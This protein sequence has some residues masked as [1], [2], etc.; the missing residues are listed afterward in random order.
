MQLKKDFLLCGWLIYNVA[1]LAQSVERGTF[2]PEVEGSS[3]SSGENIFPQSVP[4][5][6][7]YRISMSNILGI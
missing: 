7:V 2:N 4:A 1:R 3:P 5:A 6:L